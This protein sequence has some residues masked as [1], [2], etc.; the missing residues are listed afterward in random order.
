LDAQSRLSPPL[1]VAEF[2]S[3]Q[4]AEYIGK[5][6]LMQWHHVRDFITSGA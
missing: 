3:R 1:P 2:C 5:A 6:R 4:Q